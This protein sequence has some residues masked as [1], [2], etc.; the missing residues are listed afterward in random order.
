MKEKTKVFFKKISHGFQV[1]G[2]YTGTIILIFVICMGIDYL[3]HSTKHYCLGVYRDNME[4][5]YQGARSEF[6]D[7]VDSVMR[8]VAPNTCLNA[9]HVL[10]NC[11]EYNIDIFFVLAQ[12]MKESHFG[13]RGMAAKTNSVFNVWAYDGKSY[14]QINKKGKYGHPDMSVEPYMKL[15]KTRYLVNGKTESDLM[16]EYVDKNGHRYASAEDY[17]D[18]LVVA[19]KRF[20]DDKVLKDKY[21]KY[22]K[23]KTISG[24]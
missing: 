2:T 12:G 21:H 18:S 5:K 22:L 6:V 4:L 17:E 15:L 19:Y 8:V 13:T 3:V 23:F 1:A 10:K 14:K 24:N 11:E 7:A 20:A 16:I 9:I